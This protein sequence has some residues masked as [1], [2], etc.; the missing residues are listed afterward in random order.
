MLWCVEYDTIYS[1]ILHTEIDP[2]SSGRNSEQFSMKDFLIPVMGDAFALT[3]YK[4]RSSEESDKWNKWC[5][6]LK[7]YL[8]MLRVGYE[9][10]F[11]CSRKLD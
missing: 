2:T 5:G 11:S 7:W 1:H 6:C 9:P 4:E 3:D 8:A 10:S